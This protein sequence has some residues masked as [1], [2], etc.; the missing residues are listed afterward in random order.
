[1]Y[2]EQNIR[3][4]EK[5]LLIQGVHKHLLM[6]SAAALHLQMCSN[7]IFNLNHL[8]LYYAGRVRGGVTQYQYTQ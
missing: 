8:P 2:E 6:I 5:V 3:E 1:M 4:L 7:L